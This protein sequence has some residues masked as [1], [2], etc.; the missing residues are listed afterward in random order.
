[1]EILII[2]GGYHSE[3]QRAYKK[4][5]PY[6]KLRHNVLYLCVYYD[7]DQRGFYIC[8]SDRSVSYG[9]REQSKGTERIRGI[10]DEERRERICKIQGLLQ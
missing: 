7:R 10:P 6:Y 4:E 3:Q 5:K 9:M 8:K 1:M 2:P